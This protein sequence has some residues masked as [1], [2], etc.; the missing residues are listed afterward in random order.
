MKITE[1]KLRSIIRETIKNR[2]K[3]PYPSRRKQQGKQNWV[4]LC[5]WSQHSDKSKHHWGEQVF[6]E[7]FGTK[8]DAERKALEYAREENA[9][10]R[11]ELSYEEG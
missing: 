2:W 8:R 1:N 10:M 9:P 6:A 11:V 7:Y 4:I 5:D 3:D